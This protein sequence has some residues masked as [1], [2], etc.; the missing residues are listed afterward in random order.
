MR[1]M[2]IKM[3]LCLLF[4]AALLGS[5][6]SDDSK[7]ILPGGTPVEVSL[8][9]ALAGT[10]Y[11][12]VE[13]NSGSASSVRS[14]SAKAQVNESSKK[15]SPLQVSYTA[16]KASIQTSTA[17]HT[18]DATGFNEAVQLRSGTSLSNVWVL[19]F[20]STLTTGATSTAGACVAA[21]YL[22][23]VTTGDKLSPTLLTGTNQAI[24]V[25]A[26]GP[27]AGGITTASYTL[28]TF[29]SSAYFSGSIT[30]DASIPYLGRIVGGATIVA[31][32]EVYSAT[33]TPV[34]T[35][36]RI[37]AKISLDL[38]FAVSG[39][40]LTS[41]QLYNAPIN[42]YY[43]NGASTATFPT[44]SSTFISTTGILANIIPSTATS[45]TYTWYTGE[46]KRGQ[47][48]TIISVN[49]KDASHTPGNSTYCTYIRI[50]ASKIGDPYTYYN[51]DLYVGANGTT[52]FNLKRNW[53]YSI[54]VT[55]GGNETTQ[56][57]FDGV[58]GRITKVKITANSYT[59]APSASISIPVNVKGNGGNVAGTGLS[60]THTAASVG[61]VWQ[62]AAD[63]IT[64]GTFDATGQTV[65]IN[66]NASAA[67]GNAVIAAYS[68]AGETGTILWSWHIWVTNY[69]P[70]SEIT[71]TI[72]NTASA[73]YTFM[74]RNL[75]ATTS[76][77]GDVAVKGLLYQWGRKDPFPGSTTI[78]GI[79][80]PT[81]G[82]GFLF[83]SKITEITSS[84]VTVGSNL[85]NTIL[86]PGTFYL[87]TSDNGYNWYSVS[88]T[89]NDALW[90]SENK[91]SPEN[92]TIFD[93]CPA[94]WRVPAW[95]G[96]ASPWSAIGASGITTSSVGEFSNFG[97]TWSI[98]SAGFWSASG[99]RYSIDG[100]LIAVGNLGRYW[101]ASRE[102][103]DG[104]N[105]Y[106]TSSNVYP[107][108][109]NGR[110]YGYSVRC[111]QE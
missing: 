34:I 100:S 40:T 14:S 19:Q 95:K 92:K 31:D 20:D 101:S 8:S 102:S 22:G 99:C 104:D 98:I 38:N 107:T 80:E 58:D 36:Y 48:A 97:V 28:E 108:M 72:T 67:S 73:S 93:P 110:A 29:K 105:M 70:N 71:Y 103:S 1:Y 86:Y 42:M 10:E 51:Y 45:G 96:G 66:A 94:G 23:T 78:D 90:G 50:K 35:L 59:V 11:P 18:A 88:L 55:I 63:L 15:Q 3:L 41:V 25:I 33:S 54:T 69:D 49:D 65:V 9:F 64:L 17:T 24:Y 53:D 26:N 79:I 57:L 60:T 52:D 109:N 111:V 6:T 75:G 84:A 43:L 81:T 62:T 7:E 2:K 76:T 68:G 85:A 16:H 44:E 13:V 56:D 47:N 46:N 61:I 27:A 4:A 89:R 5:C 37:A 32:G 77:A 87:G 39:Y 74:D 91:I 106:L 82:N 21:K 83:S 12:Q 30:N